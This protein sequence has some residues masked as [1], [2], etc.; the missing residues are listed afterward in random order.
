LILTTRDT[1]R[2]LVVNLG[3][4][5]FDT[6]KYDLRQPAKEAL[7]KLSGIVLSHPGL[8]LEIEGHTDSVGADDFNQKL[9]EQRAD[10]V[11]AYLIVQQL[12][13]DSVSSKGFGKGRPVASN[14]TSEG[15][16]QNRRVEIIVSGEVIGVQI[17]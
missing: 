12:E 1:P 7:A 3:D 16:Q 11:R 8:R 6:G 14:D 17:R 4:V 13:P 2:G 5:L 15:R 9:S 10:A